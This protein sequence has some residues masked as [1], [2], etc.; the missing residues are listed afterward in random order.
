MM[1]H[2]VIVRLG[3]GDSGTAGR[4]FVG[5]LSLRTMEL[6]WRGNLP[7]VSCIPCGTYTL[8]R[9]KSPVKWE[10]TGGWC[11]RFD[12][13]PGRED[14]EAHY[15]NLAG[16]VRKGFKSDS[17]GCVIPGTQVMT[18]GAQLGVGHSVD[19]ME[20]LLGAVGEDDLRLEI[21]SVCAER[22]AI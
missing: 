13:V 12:E 10:K 9:W 19:A 15:G 21:V 8:R 3:T 16:D 5:E 1:Q 20:M 2:G 6:P 17:T 22:F 14:I 4:L 18:F 11:L 7:L